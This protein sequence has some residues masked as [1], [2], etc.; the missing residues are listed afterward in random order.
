LI[1]YGIIYLESN[2][3]IYPDTVLNGTVARDSRF[4]QDRYQD[5]HLDIL[6][7]L[8]RL[9]DE[10]NQD[11]YQETLQKIEV[12]EKAIA[13]CAEDIAKLKIEENAPIK[14]LDEDTSQLGE[15]VIIPILSPPEVEKEIIPIASSAEVE[16]EIIPISSSAEVEKKLI[17]EVKEEIKKRIAERQ[18]PA[19]LETKIRNYINTHRGKDIPVSN[20]FKDL[21]I[22]GNRDKQTIAKQ[23]FEKLGC[24]RTKIPSGSKN[25]TGWKLPNDW[26]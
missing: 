2:P 19:Y 1:Q 26:V 15:K 14:K 24:T 11:R 12:L 7:R 9:E 3:D 22:V 4:N 8:S 13:Q 25:I 21:G 5:I 10:S 6:D 17:Q 23:I 20:F 18:T 16:K